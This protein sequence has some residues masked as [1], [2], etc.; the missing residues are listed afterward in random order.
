MGS[1]VLHPPTLAGFESTNT[2]SRGEIVTSRPTR[3]SH[4]NL[5]SIS[6]PIQKHKP[7]A[8]TYGSLRCPDRTNFKQIYIRIIEIN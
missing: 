2:G 4:A 8:H 1:G 5:Y 3:P 6:F 7:R